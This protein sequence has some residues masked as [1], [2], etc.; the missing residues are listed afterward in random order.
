M[1]GRVTCTAFAALSATPA[2]HKLFGDG[3][4]KWVDGWPG[5]EDRDE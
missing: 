1:A 3:G 5:V 4:G 2:A